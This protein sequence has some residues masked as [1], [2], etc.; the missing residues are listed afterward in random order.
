VDEFREVLLTKCFIQSSAVPDVKFYILDLS[1]IQGKPKNK[2]KYT[3]FLFEKN[4]QAIT[5]IE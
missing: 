2:L 3:V 1:P 5:D 4:I